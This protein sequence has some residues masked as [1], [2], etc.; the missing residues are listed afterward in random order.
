MLIILGDKIDF[1]ATSYTKVLQNI[2]DFYP[3]NFIWNGVE[4]GTNSY[5]DQAS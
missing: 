4:D 3:N 1:C 5:T 2:D